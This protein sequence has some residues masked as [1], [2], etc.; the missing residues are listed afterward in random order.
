MTKTF[1]DICGSPAHDTSSPSIGQDIGEPY[2]ETKSDICGMTA[3]LW[4]HRV[5]VVARFTHINFPESVAHQPGPVD[6]CTNCM[7]VILQKLIGKLT[8]PTA[9]NPPPHLDP[10]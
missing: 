6:L 4:T 10:A 8:L 1:C 7:C 2:R 5:E 3:G 9:P